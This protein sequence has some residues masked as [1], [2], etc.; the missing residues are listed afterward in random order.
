MVP[1]AGVTPVREW[2]GAGQADDDGVSRRVK[3]RARVWG[4]V[5]NVQKWTGPTCPSTA[6]F[7][8]IDGVGWGL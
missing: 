4:T 3:K 5:L 6:E 8:L 1:P 7:A 2:D